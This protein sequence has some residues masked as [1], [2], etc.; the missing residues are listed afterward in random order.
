MYLAKEDLELIR[1]WGYLATTVAKQQFLC[2]LTQSA[3]IMS[4]LCGVGVRI[5]VH[6]NNFSKSTRP[7]DM[8]F[9]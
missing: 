6:V 9:F 7:R 3:D 4:S 2:Q 8:L 5:R 1:F